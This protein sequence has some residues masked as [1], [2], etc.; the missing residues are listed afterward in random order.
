MIDVKRHREDKERKDFYHDGY[1]VD[2]RQLTGMGTSFLK[3]QYFQRVLF[4]LGTCGTVDS[5]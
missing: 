3:V 2:D 5:S 4:N 1:G